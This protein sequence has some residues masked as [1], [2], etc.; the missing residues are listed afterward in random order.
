MTHSTAWR[1][2]LSSN[3]SYNW[4]FVACFAN[5]ACGFSLV[6]SSNL[7]DHDDGIRF[8]IVHQQFHCLLG[9]SSDN[10]I[11]SNT[12]GGRNTKTSFCYLIRSLVGQGSRFGNNPDS[13]CLEH[14]TRHDSHFRFSRSDYTWAV[15]TDQ[16]TTSFFDIGLG[17]HHVCHGNSFGDGNDYF[18]ACISSFHDGIS[19]KRWG[20]KNDRG[21]CPRL[22]YGIFYRIKHRSFQM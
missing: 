15:G 20:N 5:P 11:S 8:W 22:L 17:T 1:C 9:R 16:G 3:E 2:C 7:A 19:S 10:W 12:N 13:S 18:N 4:L 21:I 14:K 6:I